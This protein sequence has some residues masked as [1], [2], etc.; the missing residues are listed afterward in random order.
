ML[1]LGAFAA[2]ALVLA[3][4]GIYGVG[5][6]TVAQ[7]AREIGVRRALGATAGQLRRLVL[8]STLLAI[9][10]GLVA[11][12]L[13]TAAAARALASLIPAARAARVDPLIA[14]RAE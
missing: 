1:V 4:V 7:R 6:Y 14:M 11:G 9:G 8:G 2:L 5:A 12:I 3:I 13:L 10:P